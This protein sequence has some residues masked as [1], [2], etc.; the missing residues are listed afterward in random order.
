MVDASDGFAAW[1]HQNSWVKIHLAVQH[2]FSS[3]PLGF[4]VGDTPQSWTITTLISV[5]KI[6]YRGVREYWVMG[7]ER[8]EFVVGSRAREL[9]V[10]VFDGINIIICPSR[11]DSHDP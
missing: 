9:S 2:H 6:L 7:T 10:S 11:L 5:S 1:D 4:P 8:S 3:I